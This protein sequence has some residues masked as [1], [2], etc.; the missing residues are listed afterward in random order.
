MQQSKKYFIETLFSELQ[1]NQVT[2][3]KQALLKQGGCID[4]VLNDLESSQTVI[5][6]YFIKFQRYDLISKFSNYMA[7]KLKHLVENGSIKRVE[8]E[9]YRYLNLKQNPYE[10]QYHLAQNGLKGENNIICLRTGA[11]KTLISAII[12]KHWYI[13]Y[14][15]ENRLNEF[16]VAFIVPTRH[17]AEQQRNAFKVAF[18]ESPNSML[19]DISEKTTAEKLAEYYKSYNI[20]FLTA[21]K[22]V[23]AVE[24]KLIKIFGFKIMIFDECHHTS[25]LHP[26]S[27]VM[28]LYFA[29]KA[30]QKVQQAPLIIGL[31]ASLG[32][33]KGSGVKEHL[34]KFCAHL[35][36]KLVKYLKDEKYIK[37]LN[38]NVPSP[39]LDKILGVEFSR[40]QL[41][42]TRVI[43]E[44]TMRIHAE[45]GIETLNHFKIGYQEYETFVVNTRRAAE[46][47]LNRK[48]I[49]ACKYLLELNYLHNR[50]DDFSIE[51]CIE[52]SNEFLKE[53]E[54]KTPEKIET[55]CRNEYIDLIYKIES[56]AI[57]EN[58]KLKCLT[59]TIINNHK[60]NSK[61]IAY[62]NK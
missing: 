14:K 46:L 5:F 3:I 59:E 20:L 4:D 24:K 56:M 54:V 11:G 34:V 60:Q 62:K 15:N 18:H 12:C 23:N 42:I 2:E 31:T 28:N 6:E 48:L 50:I 44:K 17:L 51:L 35:D 21:K 49:I 19:I 52:K 26:F 13:Q 58:S 16:K 57:G 36:C 39:Y 55:F 8:N 37:D 27:E 47:D 53:N 33:G 29:E 32:V 45:A 41:E 9:K 40:A 25:D 22:L 7:E 1:S 30:I 43:R 10:F 61:G 38:D